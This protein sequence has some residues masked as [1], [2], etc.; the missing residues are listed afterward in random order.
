MLGEGI[1]DGWCWLAG[2]GAIG[3][4]IGAKL[5]VDV[6]VCAFALWF[7][8]LTD[9][10]VEGGCRRHCLEVGVANRGEVISVTAWGGEMACLEVCAC[11]CQGGATCK[12][13]D[14]D[15]E[16][17]IWSHWYRAAGWGSR[18]QNEWRARS[19]ERV[20]CG[21]FFFLKLQ[22]DG[23]LISMVSGGEGW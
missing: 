18:G 20:D 12:G 17:V 9:F 16:D 22:F 3:D 4:T 13:N 23:F 7:K 6:A 21:D 2:D 10:K 8:V 15:C 5:N 1:G 11:E 19:Q 14:A